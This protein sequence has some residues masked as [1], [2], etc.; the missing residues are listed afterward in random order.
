MS[1]NTN[2]NND[3]T[4]DSFNPV[5]DEIHKSFRHLRRMIGMEPPEDINDSDTGTMTNNRPPPT[6]V[7]FASLRKLVDGGST[8]CLPSAEKMK[9]S[10]TKPST[11]V[12]SP[13]RSTSSTTTA[14]NRG[15]YDDSETEDDV[16]PSPHLFVPPQSGTSPAPSLAQRS[17]WSSTPEESSRTTPDLFHPHEFVALFQQRNRASPVKNIDVSPIPHVS[18]SVIVEEEEEAEKDDDEEDEDGKIQS[19][20]RS[21][22]REL[23]NEDDNKMAS[24]GEEDSSEVAQAPPTD[25]KIENEEKVATTT[26]STT[27]YSLTT[28]LVILLSFLWLA[29]LG[30]FVIRLHQTDNLHTFLNHVK[31]GSMDS[32]TFKNLVAKVTGT[33]HVNIITQHYVDLEIKLQTAYTASQLQLQQNLEEMLQM[34]E[35]YKLKTLGVMYD[36]HRSA[37]HAWNATSTEFYNHY[38]DL[39]RTMNVTLALEM[40]MEMNTVAQEYIESATR[41][42]KERLHSIELPSNVTSLMEGMVGKANMDR[43]HRTWLDVYSKIQASVSSSIGEDSMTRFYEKMVEINNVM[44]D[45]RSNATDYYNRESKN[46]YTKIAEAIGHEKMAVLNQTWNDIQ[47]NLTRY[48]EE[49]TLKQYLQSADPSTNRQEDVADENAEVSNLPSQQVEEGDNRSDEKYFPSAGD[50][51]IGVQPNLILGDLP[52][53]VPV[54]EGNAIEHE[55]VVAED[56]DVQQLREGDNRS[57]VIEIPH[58]ATSKFDEKY[59]PAVGDE[60]IDMQPKKVT[61]DLTDDIPVEEGNAIEH[62]PVA[63]EDLDVF[64]AD[65]DVAAEARSHFELDGNVPFEVSV[66][67]EVVDEAEEIFVDDTESSEPS[68]EDEVATSEEV[69]H[70]EGDSATIVEAAFSTENVVDLPLEDVLFDQTNQEGTGDKES[71]STE[72]TTAVKGEVLENL[73][74]PKRKPL[75]NIKNALGRIFRKN[76]EEDIKDQEE[77][78]TI[79][80][81]LDDMLQNLKRDDTFVIDEKVIKEQFEKIAP[82]LKNR[83][84]R[85]GKLKNAFGKLFRQKNKKYGVTSDE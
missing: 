31:D 82:D 42:M 60:Y 78:E 1:N 14:T 70:E 3:R 43:M 57:D 77:L 18:E 80:A 79:R 59:I 62:E 16:P 50:D 65:S 71:S 54:E 85:L 17:T 67:E 34:L 7:A 48:Y 8:F 58:A 11:T 46:I 12:R 6:T 36:Y 38:A 5:S 29:L 10:C 56:S 49:S 73:S 9:R 64:L 27:A 81:S 44:N 39:E 28:K 61:G 55:P 24:D 23:E 37:G 72:S 19:V 40:Y 30:G 2:G 13:Q 32:A 35:E 15:D 76:L 33:Q 47:G 21:I 74:E 25:V 75:Q 26:S 53:D 83:P 69:D 51:G 20:S 63:T 41:R 45:L 4:E 22:F 66:M 68:D 84:K 52:E